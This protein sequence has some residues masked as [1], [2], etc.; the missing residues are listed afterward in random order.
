MF[1]ES[2]HTEAVLQMWHRLCLVLAAELGSVRATQMVPVLG[3]VKE[4]R[5]LTDACHCM[6][7]MESLKPAQERPLLGHLQQGTLGVT[8]MPVSGNDS[9]G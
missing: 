8:E 6:S 9:Q 5:R 3:G 4:S 7:G 2:Q 1:P